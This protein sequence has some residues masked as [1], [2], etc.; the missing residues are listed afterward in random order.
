MSPARKATGK[1]YERKKIKLSFEFTA[2]AS[3]NRTQLVTSVL[4]SCLQCKVIALDNFY[5]IEHHV[6]HTVFPRW[7]VT[8][9]CTVCF[10]LPH[11]SSCTA[12]LGWPPL[13]IRQSLLSASLLRLVCSKVFCC[14]QN[15]LV[16]TLQC[17]VS[18][19]TL[20]V[21][22]LPQPQP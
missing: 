6:I 1:A 15:F 16:C 4:F 3:W 10:S 17:C 21:L 9:Q 18:N 19:W 12:L 22:S 11:D 2:L 13:T 5:C 20:F 8:V 7:K 14:N